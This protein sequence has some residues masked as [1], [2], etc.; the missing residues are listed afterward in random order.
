MFFDILQDGIC[1]L[2]GLGYNG[3]DDHGNSL[4]D[5]VT[6]VKPYDLAVTCS[7]RGV[8]KAFNITT[9]EWMFRYCPVFYLDKASLTVV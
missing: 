2:T 6:N 8:I 3:N 4:W 7:L 1:I 5:G 9:N